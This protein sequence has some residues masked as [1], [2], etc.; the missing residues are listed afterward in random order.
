MTASY[1]II[2]LY[3]I[4]PTEETIVEAVRFHKYK[5]LL[6]D[7]DEIYWDNHEDL[8]LVEIQISGKFSTKVLDSISQNDQA[9]YLEYYLD[10]TGTSLLSEKEAVEFD[11]R[12]LCFF[13][14]FTDTNQP[15][16]IDDTN[17]ELPS[18]SALPKRLQPFTH[19]IPVG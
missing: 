8:T 2:G 13:I 5:W 11:N 3:S 7:T 15:L 17:L 12:R 9:P 1:N 10:P 6:N 4:I 16:Q 19:Y 14:H 18:I